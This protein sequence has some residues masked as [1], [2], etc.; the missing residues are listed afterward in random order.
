MTTEAL[1]KNITKLFSL[2]YYHMLRQPTAKK[3][4]L[5]KMLA[6]LKRRKMNDCKRRLC[7]HAPQF[8]QNF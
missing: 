1:T 7:V 4:T 8:I 2:A 6:V 5:N 3:Q